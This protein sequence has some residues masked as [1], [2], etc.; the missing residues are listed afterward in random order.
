M[1]LLQKTFQYLKMI[2]NHIKNLLNTL[3]IL[4]GFCIYIGKPTRYSTTFKSLYVIYPDFQ[5]FGLNKNDYANFKWEDK[6]LEVFVNI[7]D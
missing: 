1:K 5:Y 7:K 6:P 3:K 2:E 4:E